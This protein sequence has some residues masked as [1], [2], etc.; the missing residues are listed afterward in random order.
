MLYILIGQ[1]MAYMKLA[2]K[3]IDV[4]TMYTEAVF[5]YAYWRDWVINE[6]LHD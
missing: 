2:K 3:Y 4:Y 1:G 6:S 5:K